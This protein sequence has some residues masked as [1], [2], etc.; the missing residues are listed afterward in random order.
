M[1]PSLSVVHTEPSRRRN[2]APADS[3]P[4]KPR[5]VEQPG[6]EPLEAHRHLDEPPAEVGRDPVDHRRRHER[7]ADAAS[8]ASPAGVP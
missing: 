7:L 4:P 3:S 8:A 6:H 2:D 1:M 5:P